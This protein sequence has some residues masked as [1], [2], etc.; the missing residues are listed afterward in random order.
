M[1]LITVEDA[2][3]HLNITT[4][5]DD[6]LLGSKIAAAEAWIEQF[7]GT[8]LADMDPVPEPLKEA[9]RQL[10]GHLYEHREVNLVGLSME[11]ISPGLFDLL[12]PYRT[13]E[14]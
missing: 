12:A 9:V 2:K 8:A 5:T 7:L 3:A 14:F 1:P 6:A 11:E 10:T 4:A 13:W